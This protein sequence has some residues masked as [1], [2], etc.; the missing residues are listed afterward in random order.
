[1]TGCY[2]GVATVWG[3]IWWMC[4]NPAGPLMSFSQLRKNH[5]LDKATKFANR[6]DP[7]P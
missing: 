3:Y 7:E 1:M 4:K 6:C 2:V 5:A